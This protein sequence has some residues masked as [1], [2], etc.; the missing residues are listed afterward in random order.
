MTGGRSVFH[1]EG[2]EGLTCSFALSSSAIT[3]FGKRS[4]FLFL[5]GLF[6]ETLAGF[7][8]ASRITEHGVR[9]G[10]AGLRADCF[11]S[12]SEFELVSDSEPAVKLMGSA[13]FADQK[14]ILQQTSIPLGPGLDRLS[15]YELRPHAGPHPASPLY[16]L[17]P[18]RLTA[19]FFA[20]VRRIL[21]PERIRPSDPDAAL[22]RRLCLTRYG[23]PDWNEHRNETQGAFP[24]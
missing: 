7:G 22:I 10:P 18:A 4:A 20:V 11:D 24:Q 12:A 9:R 23:L 14:G 13:Q 1:P 2:P 17:D 8:I 3:P 19:E 6:I 15:A 16:G 5:H 21:G